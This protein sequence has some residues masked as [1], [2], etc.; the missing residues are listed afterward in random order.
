VII[1]ATITATGEQG[2]VQAIEPVANA[3]WQ[4]WA[5][6]YHKRLRSTAGDPAVTEVTAGS[7]FYAP[8]LF[9][10]FKEV[11]F[12]PAAFFALQVVRLPS[13]DI[14]TCQGGGYVASGAPGPDKLPYPVLPPGLTYL[15][16]EGAGE[17]QTPLRLP[18]G[19]PRLR[20]GDPVFFQHAKAGELAERFNDFYLV[21]G[22]E[23]VDR[24]K[25][26]RGEGMAFL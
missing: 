24:V 14:V 11:S 8:G 23:I 13:P 19:A 9:L 15:P 10:H 6:E 4:A 7:A 21:R 5:D 16:L 25:T 17:V 18:A 22:T 2:L 3:A 26:Y 20:V 1:E 12:L